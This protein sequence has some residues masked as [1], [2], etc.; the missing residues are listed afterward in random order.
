[1]RAWRWRWDQ[2][3]WN[4]ICN[5]ITGFKN[6]VPYDEFVELQHELLRVSHDVVDNAEKLHNGNGFQV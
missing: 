3:V 2:R 6:H 5:M 4:V 1:M